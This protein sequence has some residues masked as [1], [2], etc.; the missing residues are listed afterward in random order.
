MKP[1][2]FFPNKIHPSKSPFFSTLSSSSIK[3][4]SF[5]GFDEIPEQDLSKFA[6][7]SHLQIHNHHCLPPDTRPPQTNTI[8]ME[9]TTDLM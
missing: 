9:T 7:T 2:I 8:D 6:T 5:F 1:I 4:L 3:S